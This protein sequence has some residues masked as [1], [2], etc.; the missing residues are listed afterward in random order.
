MGYKVGQRWVSQTEPKLGL[1]MISE[2][3]GRRLSISFPAADEVRTYAID[4]APISRVTYKT[5]DHVA[6]HDDNEFE[7]LAMEEVNDLVFYQVKTQDGST[8][9]LSE[10]ELNC[11]IQF[12][13]P[14]QRLSNG[15]FDRN[16]AF[17]LRHDA[18]Q[19]VHALQL[20][21]VR[22]L[23]GSRT[24][25][26]AHQTYIAKA[27]AERFAPRV[28]L[29]DEV[30]LGK[31]IEAGMII[32]AQLQRGLSSRVLICV[33]ST[34]IHQW[35]VEMLRRFNLRFSIFDEARCEALIEEGVENPFESEQLVLCNL[36]TLSSNPSLTAL[37]EQAAW[38]LFVVDEAHHLEWAPDNASVE[39]QCVESIARAARGV[40]LLTAT[41]EQAG[42]E[43]HFARL[44]LLDSDRFHSLDAFV[45]QEKHYGEIS[46][47]VKR[48]Q[49]AANDA[50][51]AQ[52]LKKDLDSILTIPEDYDWDSIGEV[53]VPSL[54]NDLLDLHGTGRVLF[55][56]TREAV[57]GFPKRILIPHVLPGE[58]DEVVAS[59]A[60]DPEVT[61]LTSFLESHR[62][63]KVLVIC[64]SAERALVVE[65]Y[66]R[67]RQG[68]RTAAF[69]EGL[70]IIERDRAAAYFADREEGAQALI[71]S[72]I[73]S[74]GRNFQF[75]SNLVLLDLPKNPD[76]LE[77]RIGRLDRIGQLRDV[78]IHV[79]YIEGS[80]REGWYRWFH[81]ALN[82]FETSCPAGYAI[83][84]SFND[85]LIAYLS[86]G[87]FDSVLA[88][89]FIERAKEQQEAI[90]EEMQQGRNILLEL[91]SCRPAAAQDIIE[92]I[93]LEERSQELTSFMQRVYDLYGVEQEHQSDGSVV[94]HPGEHMITADFPCLTDQGMTL[95][96]QREKALVRE[97]MDFLT[98]E[99]PMV[100]DMLDQLVT[101]ELGNAALAKISV[102]GI[103]P[104]TLFLETVF[105]LNSMAPK[106]LQLDKYLPLSPQRFVVDI[107]GRDLSEVLAY[108]KLNG[109]CSGIKRTLALPILKEVRGE[110][111]KLLEHA[112]ARAEKQY[113]ALIAAARDQFSVDMDAEIHRLHSLQQKNPLIRE[114]ELEFLRNRKAQGLSYIDKTGLDLQAMRTIINT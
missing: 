114:E 9:N 85:E 62:D 38:D 37:A 111:P 46:E 96:Y 95:T 18:L 11:F 108:E 6:D 103:A 53:I 60:E 93:E 79:P 84:Q 7:V 92:T 99:H 63:E 67:L 82:A 22:G 57:E 35:L 55:R 13:N 71:C 109:L 91:N 45:E 39:Y 97:D 113:P 98:W 33:P 89:S 78:Q 94:L 107:D 88:L 28:L 86:E 41:P 106:H 77:Q 20:S 49:A 27:V 12:T 43:S 72:E 19:Y 100:S 26:L 68:F 47:L 74:E 21:D 83:Q 40:L 29:A 5:G 2:I 76:L 14:L 105:T 52:D 25:L 17:R 10:V 1:G 65:E 4:H 56:N 69:Y 110:L 51:I 34:L 16:R 59:L 101:G 102:K 70:S 32:H 90:A 64:A 58:P 23:L 50:P 87:D 30:G 31:T 81:E 66:L 8:T 61:W 54:T 75:A 104:G 48:L 24:S 15:H 42:Q 80:E 44:R 36:S 3:E 73:G 112:K